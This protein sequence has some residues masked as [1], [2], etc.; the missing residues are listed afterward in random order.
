[1][2]RSPVIIHTAG[3]EY[4]DLSCVCRDWGLGKTEEKRHNSFSMSKQGDGTCSRHTDIGLSPGA[5][6]KKTLW[7]ETDLGS[8]RKATELSVQ[9]N[10]DKMEEGPSGRGE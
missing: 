8:L 10:V 5:R 4:R 6:Q 7:R 9:E 2:V 1:M 3:L